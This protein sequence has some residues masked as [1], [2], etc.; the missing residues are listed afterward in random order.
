MSANSSIIQLHHGKQAV[1]HCD[2]KAG[3]ELKS[4][5]FEIPEYCHLYC[6]YCFASTNSENIRNKVGKQNNTY[7]K[8]EDYQAL[9]RNFA[10]E[11][12]EFIG[13]P[14]RGE[15][16]H[17]HNLELTKKI[18]LLAQELK[19]KTTIF[20]TGETIFFNSKY[21]AKNELDIGSEPDFDLMNFLLDKDLVIL[22]KWNSDKAEIQDKIVHTKNY[23]KLR[24]KALDMLLENNFN[25]EYTP[26]LGIVT[27]I[28]KENIDEIIDLYRKYHIKKGLIFDCDTILPRGRGEQYYNREDNLTHKQLSEVFNKLKDEGAILTCQGGTYV[29]E[30]CDRVL[31]HLYVSLKGDVYPCIG[32]F[33]NSNKHDFYLGN[34][35]NSSLKELWDK[36]IRKKLREN[37]KEAFTGV[38]FNCQNLEDNNCYSCLGRCVSSVEAS[39]NDILINTHG[40]TNHRPKI[41]PWINSTTDYVRKIISFE[42]TQSV[43]NTNLEDLWKPNQNL[44]FVLNQLS[45][46]TKKTEINKII[47]A[48]D[49]HDI[50]HYNPGEAFRKVPVRKFSQKKHYKYSDLDFPL[51]KVWDFVKYPITAEELDNSERNKLIEELSKSFL[52]NIFLPSLKLLFEKYDNDRNLLICNLLFYDNQKKKY[53]YRTVSKNETEFDAEKYNLS[54]ILFRWAEDI[55]GF[56]YYSNTSK[57]KIYNLSN[58]FR[59]EFYRDYELILNNTSNTLHENFSHQHSNIFLL[60]PLINFHLI[61]EKV[62]ALDEYLKSQ[63]KEE[64]SE[65]H[66][67]KELFNS[68]IFNDLDNEKRKKTASFY[69]NLNNVAFFSN[70]DAIIY[71]PDWIEIICEFINLNSSEPFKNILNGCDSVLDIN[72]ALTNNKGFVMTH[73][74]LLDLFL[75]LSGDNGAST[76]NYLI[77]LSYLHNKLGINHYLLTHSTNFKVS[78]YK[79]EK[80]SDESVFGEVTQPSGILLCSK[81][82][83]CREFKSEVEILLSNILQPFDE[84]YFNENIQNVKLYD[85]VQWYQHSLDN[86][87]ADVLNESKKIANTFDAFNDE[88]IKYAIESF[89]AIFKIYDISRRG[90]SRKY[91]SIAQYIELETLYSMLNL[92]FAGIIKENFD[93]KPI[94]FSCSFSN[95]QPRE[96]VL[97]FTVLWN[98]LHNAH[99]SRNK[100]QVKIIF[101]L[102]TTTLSISNAKAMDN[103]YINYINGNGFKYPSNNNRKFGG[104]AIV[105]SICK[106]L[107]I[108][109]SASTDNYGTTINLIF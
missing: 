41:I 95:R 39:D 48:K 55:D 99:K 50:S 30:P 74:P 85:E 8:W 14:G 23:T 69:K 37:T 29:G 10:A 77:F 25:Q 38:C 33:E 12:G 3:K 54:L 6:D 93:L 88:N 35:R 32:C 24:E 4:L 36:P 65:W 66:A 91:Q 86:I 18:I 75:L 34:I 80:L 59:N 100:Q 42:K 67:V 7:L 79:S 70:N 26:K 81:R 78:S 87:F 56:N 64:N 53:F 31:H 13:I 84:F 96:K 108:S 62:E 92:I 2:L 49:A 17:P 16:F 73:K 27:S 106:E 43:L 58:V 46:K 44:A 68:H 51:N 15:P 47:Q 57:G 104:L 103:K 71:R 76:I 20:T 82:S 40:C 72:I 89:D 22:I 28:I 5:W 94:N 52:S 101:N 97:I 21:T 61:Q 109:I 9:L 11:G 90:I 102:Q 19:L 45:D 98:L 107:N 83:L 60:S 63:F 1:S 105:M